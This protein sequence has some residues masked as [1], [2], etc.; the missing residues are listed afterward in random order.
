MGI[1]DLKDI[2]KTY[3]LGSGQVYQALKGINISFE[4]GELISIIGESG[5]GKST[6]MNLIGGLDSKFEGKL[7]IEGEDIGT[8]SEKALDD[9]RKN[10]VGF[11]FQNSNLI[12]HLSI[13]ENVTIAL[14]L[15]NTNKEK[16]V[17]SAKKVLQ[18]VGLEKHM[19]KRP[20]Q[21]SGGQRQRVA[22]ARA[23]VNDPEIILA[24]EPTGALDSETT[25]QVLAI[26][27]E[28]A[29]RGKLVIMVT[30]SEKVAAYSSRIVQIADG[31][32][33]MD[34]QMDRSEEINTQSSLQ[35]DRNNSQVSQ[36]RGVQ[37]SK[38]PLNQSQNLS[39]IG[40]T[41][42]AANNMKQKLKRNILVAVG[43]S[44]G[45]MSIITM[46]ALG[47]GLKAYFSNMINSFMN[48]LVVEVSM[49]QEINPENINP[50]QAMQNLIGTKLT[51]EEENLKELEAIEGVKA[52]EK[53]FQYLSIAGSNFVRD[54]EEKIDLM[55]IMSTSSV[56]TDS[57]V[58][59]GTL[60]QENEILVNRSV[61]YA[62]GDDAIGKT[63]EVNATIDGEVLQKEFVIS[64]IY[65][66]G[67]NN[68]MADRSNTVYMNYADLEAL[69]AEGGKV[70]E[71]N[72]MYL[73]AET[74]ADAVVIKEVITDLGYGGSAQEMMGSQML[75]MLN[76]MTAVLSGIAG[77]SL[78]VSS[79]MILVVLYIS[80]VERTKEIGLLRA[81]GARS[82]DI[83][84]IF[85]SEAFLIGLSSG[86]I[87]LIITSLA[88]IAVNNL[89]MQTFEME[90]MHVT[91]PYMLIGIGMSVGVSMLSGLFPANQAARLDPVDSLRTE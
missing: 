40:A 68:S 37:N 11:I 80:V 32:I 46:F 8:F 6:L 9:Y 30:H 52:L 2:N 67:E 82:K 7:L 48:P 78:V 19:S 24:D 73:I 91:W 54:G 20:N 60:P 59:E 75:T 62:M 50:Q 43:V 21:L 33:I 55:G 39:F 58:E 84:R 38:H 56:L 77:I 69:V 29:A 14:T 51:F 81:I 15:S 10:K 72:T 27:K 57:N 61:A 79:I 41:R 89:T 13:L 64:G 42:L 5:S 3:Q 66:A 28:I 74:E 34:K 35:D 88:S 49:K 76:V 36:Q 25:I 26:I 31:E 1:L 23:L 83:R 47:D 87:G 12:P 71:P 22:I 18:Q 53:G 90:V 16:R 4:R 85:V 44:I 86:V 65:I 45:I 17:A 70:L 63:V